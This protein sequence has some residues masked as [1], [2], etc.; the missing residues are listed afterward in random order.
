[1]KLN[2]QTENEV[3]LNLEILKWT[4]T[5]HVFWAIILQ[6]KT[7]HLLN[8]D[9][10]NWKQGCYFQTWKFHNEKGSRCLLNFET[11]KWKRHMLSYDPWN[12]KLKTYLLSEPWN[13]KM[14]TA[15]VVFW[16]LKLQ[17]ENDPCCL[18]KLSLNIQDENESSVWRK[19]RWCWN[20]LRLTIARDPHKTSLGPEPP[21]PVTAIS[22]TS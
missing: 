12:L 2:L 1:M 9:T 17:N 19:T 15:H 22:R 10:S 5:A 18:L 21:L 20:Q 14:K 13:F 16:T 6:N 11:S 7:I 3:F 4:E 8:F